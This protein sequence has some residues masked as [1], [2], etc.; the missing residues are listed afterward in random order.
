MTDIP[1]KIVPVVFVPYSILVGRMYFANIHSQLRDGSQSRSSLF[2]KR[3]PQY[4]LHFPLRLTVNIHNSS[5]RRQL[6]G[7]NPDL[8]FLHYF[9]S[10]NLNVLYLHGCYSTLSLNY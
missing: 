4:K 1:M 5:K 9:K 3:V 7:P 2:S 8:G 10:L 6:Q